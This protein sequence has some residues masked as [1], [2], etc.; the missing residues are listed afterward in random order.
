MGYTFRKWEV[1][2]MMGIGGKYE[3]PTDNAALE[4]WSVW[5]KMGVTF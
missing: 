3:W 2:M 5:G 1:P 4:Q